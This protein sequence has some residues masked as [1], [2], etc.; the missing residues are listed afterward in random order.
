MSLSETEELA[1]P[2]QI[3]IFLADSRQIKYLRP[4][5]ALT[6]NPEVL[7]M[8]KARFGDSNVQIKVTKI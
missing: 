5:Y 1:G 8:L 4:E 2:V 3:G 6:V 7:R